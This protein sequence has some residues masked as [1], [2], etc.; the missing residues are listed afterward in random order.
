M[1]SVLA[2]AAL[3]AV[4]A[5]V[6]TATVVFVVE[7]LQPGFFRRDDAVN[8]FLPYLSEMSRLWTSGQLP[9]LTSHS[10][11]GGNF[12]IDF[13]RSMF[14]PIVVIA[15]FAYPLIDS[16]A[17]VA[18]LM[19]GLNIWS[20]MV[21]GYTAA[22]A[23][24]V[25]RWM[26]WATALGLA[27]G[28]LFF[29][30]YA[31]SWWNAAIAS[32]AILWLI[33]ALEW[34]A[35]RRTIGSVVVVGVAVLLNM[36]VG[37]PHGYI[38][39]AILFVAYAV[40]LSL[41]ERAA[42]AARWWLTALP[43]V[44]AAMLP[45][46]VVMPLLS[47]FLTQGSNFARQ[48][49]VYNDNF[50]TP[51]LSQLLNVFNPTGGDLWNIYGGFRWW[52]LPIGY[53]S[54]SV[55]LLV[56]VRN[57]REQLRRPDLLML[58]AL[59]G[60]FLFLS[61]MP[62]QFGP[63]RS[64]FRFLPYVGGF[65]LLAQAL[66]I[67]RAVF[68]FTRVRAAII[69]G[70]MFFAAIFASWRVA[71][72]R[73]DVRYA[74]V[75]PALSVVLLCVV[76]ILCLRYRKV[77]AAALALTIGGVLLLFAQVPR[78]LS[79][80]YLGT[81]SFPDFAAAEPNLQKIPE[82]FV[83][84]AS[85]YYSF[86]NAVLPEFSAARYLLADKR[87]M[88]GY[89]PVGFAPYNDRLQPLAVQ[90][91]LPLTAVDTLAQP[92][93][94]DPSV[95]DLTVW[96]IRSVVTL[97]DPDDARAPLLEECGFTRIATGLADSLWVDDSRPM[98]G[99][100]SW[101]SPGTSVSNDTELSDRHERIQ[102]RNDSGSTGTVAFARMAWP[103]FTAESAGQP[104]TVGKYEDTLVTV[105]VP[106]GFDGQIDLS[107]TPPSWRWALPLSGAALLAGIVLAGLGVFRERK[108][109]VTD[110]SDRTGV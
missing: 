26:R 4:V 25:N 7:T 56:F 104:L 58:L 59:A 64:S 50:G 93:S 45:I 73:D 42:G 17:N 44:F 102:V 2:R 81:S 27:F 30:L 103:G 89:D 19:A 35:R 69:I 97:T 14:Y 54:L 10:L 85:T 94:L 11:N 21:A 84:H 106:A 65:L 70:I 39:L 62:S 33:A 79:D 38:A 49:G 67:S 68:R 37:W 6:V 82:G 110:V 51:S 63:L 77:A 15:A 78:G 36:L 5:A 90:G 87:I 34:Y 83:L 53:V 92:S 60:L 66:L 100:V 95:C 57:W 105:E 107:Y 13:Q 98:T 22:A 3:V 43:L 12:L 48:S 80:T 61:Q 8:E 75:M 108:E 18:L 86:G 72:P 101:A 28:P 9:I 96:G 109:R 32:S 47:E 91:H 52:P 99:T 31:T 76:V 23:F 40:R 1:R 71:T 20:V 41:Q 88:N 24:G 55:L 29:F 16:P 74:Y 46:L